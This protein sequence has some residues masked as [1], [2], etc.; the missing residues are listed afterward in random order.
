MASSVTKTASLTAFRKGQQKRE[1]PRKLSEQLGDSM[2]A[3]DMEND[4][5]LPKS[6]P[7]E[8]QWLQQGTVHKR[9]LDHNA[10]WQERRLILTRDAIFF[11]RPREFESDL[12]LDVLWLHEVS[13]VEIARPKSDLTSD[14]KTAESS[15]RASGG[16]GMGKYGILEES[17]ATLGAVKSAAKP[18]EYKFDVYAGSAAHGRRC[19]CLRSPSYEEQTTWVK[20]LQ[21]HSKRAREEHELSHMD[22]NS[23]E[24]FRARLKR[25]YESNNTQVSVSLCL[26]LSCAIML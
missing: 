24:R 4:T 18:S 26:C 14:D 19:Y 16:A 22:H 25:W 5:D 17:Q 3:I 1:I 10:I 21:L 12:I 2:D 15:A 8:E 23:V 7:P 13:H 11:T 20:L 6:L 9:T